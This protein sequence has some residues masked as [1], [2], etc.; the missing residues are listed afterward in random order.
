MAQNDITALAVCLCRHGHIAYLM[1]ALTG[2]KHAY[3][4]L[5][6]KVVLACIHMLL[7]V[8]YDINC[9]WAPSFMKWLALQAHTIRAKAAK[10]QFPLPR[11]HYFAHRWEPQCA[12]YFG[13]ELLACQ[14]FC[15]ML[16]LISE[17]MHLCCRPECQQEFGHV[18]MEGAGRS[19][20]E[21]HEIFNSQF[22]PLGK[23]TMYMTRLNRE[24]R[25]LCQVSSICIMLSSI[26]LSASSRQTKEESTCIACTKQLFLWMQARLERA[27][28]FYTK[29][30]ALH[31]PAQLVRMLMRALT[32]AQE[33]QSAVERL[34]IEL[35]QKGLT[36]DE[37]GVLYT[38]TVV[39]A[40]L[41]GFGC[42]VAC[43]RQSA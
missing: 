32:A 3:A 25:Q 19:N 31:L 30:K 36:V 6:V 7:F 24:V 8:W 23:T 34:S 27:S 35:L 18:H 5:F 2:E 33:A 28:A 9:R 41:V 20:G 13:T 26:L 39:A 14:N 1:N 4:T 16:Q 17:L 15:P 10:L 12:L 38:R 21:P 22:A 43:C 29:E 40:L 11:M 42:S 37:V